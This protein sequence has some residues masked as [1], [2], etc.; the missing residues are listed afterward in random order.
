MKAERDQALADIWGLESL[1]ELNELADMG[2]EVRL[3]QTTAH[4][5]RVRVELHTG[6]T[7]YDYRATTTA[8]SSMTT[9]VRRAVRKFHEARLAGEIPE[10]AG[11]PQRAG[12]S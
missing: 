6:R 4:A 10:P 11:A 12:V 9:A 7:F 5:Y 2:C 8:T 1:D 3:D